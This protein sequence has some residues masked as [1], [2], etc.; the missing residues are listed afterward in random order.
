MLNTILIREKKFF[1]QK[2]IRFDYNTFSQSA[3][4]HPGFWSLIDFTRNRA[5]SD[6]TRWKID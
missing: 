2:E 4:R 5:R 6:E 3:T 1:S